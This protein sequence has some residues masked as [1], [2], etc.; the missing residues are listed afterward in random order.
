MIFD[1]S[2]DLDAAMQQF[3]DNELV[4]AAAQQAQQACP[5]TP[6]KA[7]QPSADMQQHPEPA[8][9]SAADTSARQQAGQHTDTATNATPL[10]F[11]QEIAHI[12][13]T[14]LKIPPDRLDVRENMSRYG[15][16][17][18]I[19]TEIMKRISDLLD[20]PIAPTV[21]FEARHLD[22]L[23]D[24]LYQRYR[25]TIEKRV[26]NEE[27]QPVDKV[28]QG[29]AVVQAVGA[30]DIDS[31]EI[32]SEVK[33]WISKFRAS[34]ASGPQ[35]HAVDQ[36]DRRQ[37]PS[38]V[39]SPGE[40]G[41][42][43]VAII[44]MEGIFP[45]S[46]NLQEFEKH[47]RQGDDCISEIPAERWD[48]QQVYGDPKQGEFTKVKY[49][50]FAPDID[51][52]DPLFFGMSPREAELM[53][54]QHRL[55]IQCVWK[56]IESAG[57]APK[58][59]SGRKIGLFM[60]INL[61]DYAHLID[62]AGAMEALHLTSLGH[63][64]CPNR[65]SFFLDIHGPS[66]VIDTA[67]SSS[68]VALHRAVLSIQHEGCE[69]AIAGGANLLI[70]PDMHIMYSKVGM[71][72]EDG[73]CKTFSEQ[74][75]GYVRSDGVGAVL[76]KSLKR[77]EQDGDT[78]LGV[79]RG[80]AE[81]HGGMS[82]SLTAP[83]PKAQASLIVEAHQKANIDPRS[84]GYI[85][86]HGTGTSLGDPIEINGLKMAFEQLHRS[87][88]IAMPDAAYCGLGSVKSNIGHAETAA[89][90]AGVIKAVLALRHQR[91]YRSLHCDAINPMIE[92][93]QS[94][95]FILQQGQPWQRSVIDGK[96]QPRRAG[97]SSFG[98]GGSN[99]HVVIEEYIEQPLPPV[100][101][102][103]PALILLSA[104]NEAPLG[105]VVDT[106]LRFLN[107]M[108]DSETPDIADIAFTLQVGREAMAERLAV[109]ADSVAE[110]KAKLGRME[111]VDCYKGTVTRNK[112]A[113]RA[114]NEDDALPENV[115]QRFA[116][117]NVRQLAE[118][119]VKGVNIDWQAL[120]DETAF[121]GRR[122]RRVTL[123]SYPFARQ[124]YWLPE[125]GG[126]RRISQAPA[127]L[128]PLMH[129]NTSDLS[130]QRFSSVFSATEFFLADHVVMGEKVLPGV[131]Y[132]EMARAAVKQVSAEVDSN[133]VNIRLKNVVWARPFVLGNQPTPLHIGLHPEQHNQIA[134]RIY[135]KVGDAAVLHSQGTAVLLQP[136]STDDAG[137]E[138]LDLAAL[139][140]KITAGRPELNSLDAGQCYDAFRA[141]GIEYGPGHQGLETVYFS[142]PGNA[143][144]VTEDRAI[145]NTAD[146]KP[147]PEGVGWVRGNQNKEKSLFISPHPSLIMADCPV[148]HP[149][150]E[151]KSA[152][153]GFVPEGEGAH[154]PP[155]VLAKL[156]LPACVESGAAQFVLHPGLMDSGLQACIGLMVGSGH[157][158]PTGAASGA[159]ETAASLPFALDELTLLAQPSATMWA[160]IRYADGSSP[161]DKVQ[162]LNIDL[163]DDQGRICVRMKGFSSRS[164]EQKQ[165]V[166]TSAMLM[167]KPVWTDQVVDGD[168][169]NQVWE[170]HLVVL[171]DLDRHF[172]DSI[173]QDIAAKI[174]GVSCS[175]L[176]LNGAVEDNYQDAAIKIFEMI[177]QAFTRK[178]TGNTLLQVLIPGRGKGMLFGGLSGLLKTANRENARF[179]G[180]L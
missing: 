96:E 46:P 11:R 1:G 113:L 47:L 51:K 101:R 180:Q 152:P 31:A 132:L 42:E 144:A 106:L 52:F 142:A 23:A 108:T 90:I 117:G 98:A 154:A 68:L 74:A 130:E 122:P 70:S 7:K 129:Q 34:A 105:D 100:Q 158:L 65:L 27:V 13:S 165:A 6:E 167:C 35:V 5:C 133:P 157:A 85:E 57:Y 39:C 79:I 174:A 4:E 88:G 134:Y 93:D 109:I 97:V 86:C 177:K 143:A 127:Q 48:W 155:Q 163:C 110:L 83:N 89:G 148:R 55:F 92:L 9:V 19:V 14:V 21:F 84:I 103:A 62:R 161:T 107:G 22:E 77:A 104:K 60:G 171:C 164:L 95:F 120:Y 33:S 116:E 121:T 112:E 141:M 73:R 162:K 38:N 49:G 99:A 25:K 91:L 166:E 176:H 45:D 94:P 126:N 102:L 69:M 61:Q 72:C 76:L 64:F 140:D 71:I 66:Q 67:C 115:R 30:A 173:E 80:S 159:P 10:R 41:Y 36:T 43:P 111:A 82:T 139:R 18:I 44:A 128:H 168:A 59:L 37:T 56:L 150:G 17:S 78:I 136:G 15:V 32:D 146:L 40:T 138:K 147:S 119:W 169:E 75:N 118:L 160:W 153:G 175:R 81:N 123:P 16:D 24:I 124:R 137:E 29:A 54:P 8:P 20:L 58:S 145:V 87:T 151:C 172:A 26:L 179:F 50:G 63:M 131:A 170:R 125:T 135:S 3:L 156:V 178:T 28:S 12:A 53:D 114:L 2:E 149:A